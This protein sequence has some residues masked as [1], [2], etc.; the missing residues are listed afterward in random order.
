MKIAVVRYANI[1]GE[2]SHH[3][4]GFDFYHKLR[5]NPHELTIL[6]DGSQQKSYLHVSDAVSAS[7]L[8]G[9]HLDSQ[10]LPI[11]IFNVGSDDWFTV[12]DITHIYESELGLS[13]VNHIYTGG[14]KGWV[15][16]VAKF[17]M[18]S[19]KIK[20]LGFRPIVSFREGV[21]RYI[22]WLKKTQ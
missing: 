19:E 22:N 11:D 10:I 15:G 21:K 20:I 8:V 3:G 16:D 5:D 18:S 14:S 12:N 17:L 4:I 7:I 1:F 13:N 9:D 6:G 2:R